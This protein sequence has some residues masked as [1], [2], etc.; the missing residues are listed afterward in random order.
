MGVRDE[1]TVSPAVGVGEH[2][3]PAS[4]V[5]DDDEDDD[6]DLDLQDRAR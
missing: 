1:G 3:L 4:V 2:V 6:D 5:N